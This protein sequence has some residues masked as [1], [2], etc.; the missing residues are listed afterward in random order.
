MRDSVRDGVTGWLV[1]EPDGP[2]RAALAAALATGIEGALDELSEPGRRSEVAEDCRAWAARFGWERM[3]AEVVE[4]VV[5][6]IWARAQIVARR[7]LG[8]DRHYC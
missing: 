1:A 3:R 2:D 8:G 4:T 7:R 6:D 5:R